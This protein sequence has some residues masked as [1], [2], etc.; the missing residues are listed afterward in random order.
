MKDPNQM[1]TD[2][3]LAELFGQPVYVTNLADETDFPI[4]E[5]MSPTVWEPAGAHIGFLD[6]IFLKGDKRTAKEQM[7]DRYA[8]GGGFYTNDDWAT[9]FRVLRSGAIKYPGDQ[10]LYPVATT[11]LDSGETVIVYDGAFVRIVQEDGSYVIT[12]MD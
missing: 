7:N 9:K 3:L 5:G 10:A 4:P 11:K 12:R 2:E 8:H 1:T 6:R